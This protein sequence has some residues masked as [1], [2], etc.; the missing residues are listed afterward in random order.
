MSSSPTVLALSGGVGGAKLSLGLA[1]VLPPGELAVLV[2]TGDDFDHLG[3]RICPDLDTVTYTL[4]G[5]VHPE[6]GWGRAEESFGV[7]N[8]LRR[9]GGPDWF[10]LGDRD[11]V[12]HLERTRRLAARERL[13]TI[14]ASF[15]DRFGVHTR[16]LP[17]S[18][19]PVATRVE[20][21]VGELAFQHYFVRLRCAPR[22]SSIRFAGAAEARPTEELLML[23]RQPALR[24]I[25][26]C[27]S[28]P[29]LSIDPILA[30]S[31]MRTALR[32]AGVPIVAVSPLIGGRAVKGPT[33]KLMQELGVPTEPAAIVRH[34]AGLLDG[35]VLDD[36][37]AAQVPAL[38]S[39]G[40]RVAL[41][42]TLMR[43]LEDRERVAQVALGLA[44]S[45]TAQRGA[46]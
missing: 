32:A 15:A 12:L 20:T 24:A 23:L 40:L 33:A 8:E 11:L 14:A 34:Y 38:E 1:R 31:G 17:M 39:L 9:H 22:V 42:A 28:N 37:D 29:Y 2:N 36:S 25:V 44:E 43:S 18:D 4:G 5:I 21:E 6:Q 10:L 45:L 27:P 3:L 19:S 46:A 35:V 26:L 13:T 7:M 30:V 16:V 41:T